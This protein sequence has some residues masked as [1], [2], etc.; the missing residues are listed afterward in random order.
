MSKWL[1]SR[2]RSLAASHCRPLEMINDARSRRRGG[3]PPWLA[4]LSRHSGVTT[5]S[6]EPSRSSARR[7]RQ[8]I[9]V[10]LRG[11]T[12]RQPRSI[13]PRLVRWTH[14]SPQAL[15]RPTSCSAR[16]PKPAGD[17]QQQLLADVGPD[18]DASGGR[19]RLTRTRNPRVRVR[20]KRHHVHVPDAPVPQY[21]EMLWPTL[22]AVLEL[23]GS[24]S[25]GEIVVNGH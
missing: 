19:L 12:P 7:G 10:T 22:Q 9:W 16:F 20:N 4:G 11:F 25:I 21:H 17:S 3:V 13:R 6:R 14:A 23:G 8:S 15:H 2:A 18:A 1:C 5:G 24:G